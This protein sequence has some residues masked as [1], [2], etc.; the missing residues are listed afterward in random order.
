MITAY[1]DGACEPKNPGGNMGLGVHIDTGNEIIEYSNF[2]PKDPTNSNNVAEYLAF[3]FI[4]DFLIAEELTQHPIRI[5]GD[6]QLVVRQ[7]NREWRIINGQYK[8]IANRVWEKIQS[9]NFLALTIRWIPREENEKADKLSKQKFKEN[10]IPIKIY[11]NK[12]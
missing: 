4:I 8:V 6:S 3:E 2:F 12:Q 1:F 10:K 7:M 11:L 9:N 5:Y